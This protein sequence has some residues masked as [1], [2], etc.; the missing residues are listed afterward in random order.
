MLVNTCPPIA[1]LSQLM[2]PLRPINVN[3]RMGIFSHGIVLLIN[4]QTEDSDC[5]LVS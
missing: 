3:R 4:A 5:V 2:E 1:M